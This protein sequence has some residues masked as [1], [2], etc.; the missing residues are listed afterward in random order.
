MLSQAHLLEAPLE[1]SLVGLVDVP[2]LASREELLTDDGH[3]SFDLSLV[4]SHG[5]L[6]WVGH[7]TIVSLEFGV[8]W[9]EGG[10]VQIRPQ[11]SV[12]QIVEHDQGG[13]PPKE[14]QGADMTVQPGAVVLPKHK[15]HEAMATVAEDQDKGPGSAQLAALPDPASVRHTQNQL[16]LAPQLEGAGAR[17]P[18]SPVAGCGC[19]RNDVRSCS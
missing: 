13:T 14:L 10:I 1:R 11:D 5:H 17:S 8:G 16:E 12:F 4:T 6:G 3:T 2:K 7:E 19:V 15:A 18:A 9:V